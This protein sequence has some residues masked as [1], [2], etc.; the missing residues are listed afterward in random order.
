MNLL[1]TLLAMSAVRERREHLHFDEPAKPK[2]RYPKS[3]PAGYWQQPT[4]LQHMHAAARR[5]V[6][7]INPKAQ[8]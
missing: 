3:V 7:L 5:R 4:P 8:D 1:T 6:L 2:R